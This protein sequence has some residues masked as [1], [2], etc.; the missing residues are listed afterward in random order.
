MRGH[1]HGK[2]YGTVDNVAESEADAEY[3]A[4]F[5]VTHRGN[6]H[7]LGEFLSKDAALAAVN[8]FDRTSS[9]IGI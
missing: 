3:W 7:C 4:V 8:G 5:G 9:K 2:W 1:S 6:R